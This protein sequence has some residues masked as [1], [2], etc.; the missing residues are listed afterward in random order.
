MSNIKLKAWIRTATTLTLL[1][2]SNAAYAGRPLTVDDANVDDAG[3]GHVESWLSRNAD[4]S[5]AF[6]IVPAYSFAKNWEL[7]GFFSRNNSAGVNTAALQI[8]TLFTEP[9]KSGCNIA[10]VLGASRTESGG[11]AS[12]SPYVNGILTCN[13]GE[14]ALHFNLGAIK[15]S[16]SG[17][18]GSSTLATWG[19]AMEE[20]VS[21]DFSGHIEVFGQQGSKSTVQ[22]GLKK[23]VGAVQLDGTIGRTDNL[24]SYSFGVKFTF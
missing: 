3:T 11:A 13:Q 8:K 7:D 24:N 18:L 12:N 14:F 23:Q 4:K 9:Q 2:I 5:N 22:F 20:F 21:K 16:S 15:P 10:G 19:A 6:S 17:S 1:L